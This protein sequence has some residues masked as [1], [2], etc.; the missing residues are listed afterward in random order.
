MRENAR[1]LTEFFSDIKYTTKLAFG[2]GFY[3]FVF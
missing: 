3:H 2:D 1:R